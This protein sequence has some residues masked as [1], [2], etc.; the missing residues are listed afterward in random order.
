VVDGVTIDK[1]ESA[2]SDDVINWTSTSVGVSK[3]L[4]EAFFTKNTGA[5]NNLGRAL[6]VMSIGKAI[7][8]DDDKAALLG[9]LNWAAA[10]VIG[11]FSPKTGTFLTYFQAYV[12]GVKLLRSGMV[13]YMKGEVYIAYCKGRENNPA[14]SPADVCNNILYFTVDVRKHF[15]NQ[16]LSEKYNMREKDLTEKYRA[17]ILR[18]AELLMAR[19]FEEMY[20]KEKLLKDIEIARKNAEK[21]GQKY[22]EE[23]KEKLRMPVSGI[24]VDSKT[25]K[26]V[27]G[28]QLGIEG[29]TKTLSNQANG[30][31]KFRVWYKTVNGKDFYVYA[32]KGSFY[33]KKLVSWKTKKPPFLTFNISDE[34][35]KPKKKKGKAQ[36]SF[37]LNMEYIKGSY[38]IEQVF[39]EHN[40]VG[41]ALQTKKIIII[42]SGQKPRTYSYAIAVRVNGKSKKIVPGI[43]LSPFNKGVTI[44]YEGVDDNGNKIEVKASKTLPKR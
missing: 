27:S 37:K 15:F 20:L 7:Y 10:E 21:S 4:I 30:T 2:S 5:L 24:V 33:Q 38:K 34:E 17:R 11:K 12:V 19:T 39:S 6:T 43:K 29:I 22:L 32:K 28:V 14:W 1:P 16:L 18:E 40:G 31:F 36:L 8:E 3:E 23:I 41:V 35:K 42:D 13:K 25:R 26:K 44:T 9:A